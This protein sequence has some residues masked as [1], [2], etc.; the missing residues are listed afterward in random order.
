MSVE[1]A[2]HRLE[3]QRLPLA[4]DVSKGVLQ[5]EVAAHRVV[6]VD[7]GGPHPE[8]LPR[9]AMLFGP[10]CVEAAV[11]IPHWLWVTMMRMGN[12]CPGRLLHTRQLAKSPSAV[13]ASPPVTM[14]MPSPPK[15][16][17]AIAVPGAMTYWTSMGELTGAT[18]QALAEVPGEVSST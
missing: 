6:A 5:R 14:V 13:P 1:A 18:F 10:R 3:E 8:G 16:F 12:S 7:R 2:H 15:R 11:E 9:S 4:S 17:C